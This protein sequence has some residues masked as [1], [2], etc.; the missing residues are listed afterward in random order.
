MPKPVLVDAD[1]NPKIHIPFSP[2]KEC[3]M[4][5]SQNTRD[6][7]RYIALDILQEYVLAGGM[8]AAQDRD[9]EVSRAGSGEPARGEGTFISN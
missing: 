8:N 6:I 9:R 1:S 7:Q 3:S 4:K 5:I 2:I